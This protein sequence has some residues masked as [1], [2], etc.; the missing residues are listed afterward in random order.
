[1]TNFVYDPK[2]QGYD[3][4]LWKTLTGAPTV[5]SDNIVLNEDEIIG[6]ADL[7]EGDITMR[8]IIPTV[9]TTGD[10]RK[11]GFA[12]AGFGALLVFEID[13]EDF[14]IYSD[15]GDGDTQSVTVDFK[16][17]WATAEVDFEIR[18]R[19]DYADFLVN[20]VKVIDTTSEAIGSYRLGTLLGT[21][22]ISKGPMSLYLQNV[23]V[24]NMEIVSI[25]AKNIQTFI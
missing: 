21:S 5:S 25:N 10:S 4:S 8:L 22:S 1:M 11:F 9:P 3:A 2:R 6:Y 7:Y 12:S 13:G 20:G 24:D 17:A 23:N 16:A 19:G 15:N 14:N 18:W